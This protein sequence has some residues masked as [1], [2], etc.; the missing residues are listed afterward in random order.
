MENTAERIFSVSLISYDQPDY[1]QQA[2]Y[3]VLI[4]DYPAVQL[5]FSDDGS[6]NFNKLEVEDFIEKNKGNNLVSYTVITHKDNIG[7]MRNLN[8]ADAACDGYYITHLEG[9]DAFANKHVLSEYAKALET[10]PDDALG[11]FGKRIA[12]D[13]NLTILP[14]ASVYVQNYFSI[15]EMLEMNSM[16]SRELYRYLTLKGNCRLPWGASAFKLSNYNR[17]LPLDTRVSYIGDWPFFLKIT[18]EGNTMSF[19]D[20]DAILYRRGG[21]STS[22]ELTPLKKKYLSDRAKVYA[23]E[24]FPFVNEFFTPE[25]RVEIFETYSSI[26]RTDPSEADLAAVSAVIAQDEHAAALVIA[27]MTKLYRDECSKSRGSASIAVQDGWINQ[28][29]EGKDWLEDQYKKLTHE[30]SELKQREREAK[31]SLQR[32]KASTSWK[33]GRAATSIPRAIVKNVRRK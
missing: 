14:S 24:I 15:D 32:I 12:C 19:A 16:T 17:H 9:D 31:K 7:T 23:H 22:T 6:P 25:E 18:R 10:A 33:I 11:V 13:E 21:I 2:V 5:I 3:S 8:D 27:K 30:N 26:Q 28:L 20:I 4:Q 1:W 29:Q